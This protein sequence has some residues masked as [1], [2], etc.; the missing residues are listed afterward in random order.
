MRVGELMPVDRQGV[1]MDEMLDAF[2][3]ECDIYG[4]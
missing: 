4:K 2:E 3:K 1:I